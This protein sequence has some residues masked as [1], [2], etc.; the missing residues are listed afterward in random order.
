MKTQ[1]LFQGLWQLCTRFSPFLSFNSPTAIQ[2]LQIFDV[3]FT[4]SPVAKST[5]FWPGFSTPF[6]LSLLSV[7]GRT[8][9]PDLLTYWKQQ[10]ILINFYSYLPFICQ[11]FCSA[12][13]YMFSTKAF[14][15]AVKTLLLY[16]HSCHLALISPWILS[17]Q[18]SLSLLLR[19]SLPSH[20]LSLS[21]LLPL[22][23]RPSSRSSHQQLHLPILTVYWQALAPP[24]QE[25]FLWIAL[26][27]NY[28]SNYLHESCE[29]RV[30]FCFIDDSSVSWIQHHLDYE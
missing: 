22:F 5:E 27:L 9:W 21:C 26:C 23:H 17:L 11:H 18:I 8:T 25:G 20:T 15:R 24:S 16:L 14:P 3:F 2:F 10:T 4:R 19:K 28:T 6:R 12:C 7:S 29:R 13:C 1:V 30:L